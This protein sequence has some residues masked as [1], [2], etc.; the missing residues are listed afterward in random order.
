MLRNHESLSKRSF[1]PALLLPPG[2]IFVNYR[3]CVEAEQGQR[4][5]DAREKSPLFASRQEGTIRQC[6]QPSVVL[7]AEAGVDSRCM[8]AMRCTLI[9][10]HPKVRAENSASSSSD[11]V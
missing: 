3:V 10:S 4:L 11:T 7:V 2:T 1:L 9:C 5:C 8:V 6:W